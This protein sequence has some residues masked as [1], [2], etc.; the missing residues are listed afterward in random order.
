MNVEHPRL[1]ATA[2][3]DALFRRPLDGHVLRNLEGR[4]E[5]DLRPGQAWVETDHLTAGCLV[6]SDRIEPATLPPRVF[7]TRRRRP[8]SKLARP[9][10]EGFGRALLIRAGAECN[11]RESERRAT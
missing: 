11:D 7:V 8:R 3:R 10:G 2:D 5:G 4:V 1:S 9:C 6:E